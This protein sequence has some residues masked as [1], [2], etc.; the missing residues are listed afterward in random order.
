MDDLP[1]IELINNK[2]LSISFSNPVIHAPKNFPVHKTF[3]GFKGKK[4]LS[5]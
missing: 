5:H 2:T 1:G 4:N 3:L